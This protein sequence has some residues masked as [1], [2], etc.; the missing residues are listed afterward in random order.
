MKQKT[1]RPYLLHILD[2]INA[3]E[4]FSKK[5]TFNTFCTDDYFQSA[6]IKKLEIIGEAAA[7]ISKEL[8]I[9]TVEIPWRPI[10]GARNRLIHGYFAVDEE[11]VW[12]MI[13]VDIPVL[14]KQIESLLQTLGQE[15]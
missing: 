10:V 14:K 7:H 9:H 8:K 15:E 5:K 4:K 11:K 6:V 2:A 12:K 1:D 13:A 3:I